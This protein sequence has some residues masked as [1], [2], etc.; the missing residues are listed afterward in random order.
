MLHGTTGSRNPPTEAEIE[1]YLYKDYSIQPYRI[2]R[3]DGTD[4]MI[5]EHVAIHIINSYCANLTNS[6]F[7]TLTAAWV[8][9]SFD[10]SYMVNIKIFYETT[11]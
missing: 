2:K 6:Q 1:A 10:D 3:K 8:L 9:K 7:V 11:K 5:T 4:S